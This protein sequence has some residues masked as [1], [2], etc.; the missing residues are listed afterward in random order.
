MSA[1]INAAPGLLVDALEIERERYREL[2]GHIERAAAHI[3]ADEAE[4]QTRSARMSGIERAIV[5]LGGQVPPETSDDKSCAD[6]MRDHQ[7]MSANAR[8]MLRAVPTNTGVGLF[9]E[10]D[11]SLIAAHG[12][13]EVLK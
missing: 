6:Y 1:G 8:P 7:G 4:M 3:K 12:I 9:V 5:T 2:Q 11:S 10:S 13:A